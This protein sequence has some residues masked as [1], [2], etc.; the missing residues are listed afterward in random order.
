MEGSP[1]RPRLAIVVALA[2]LTLV[3][4]SCRSTLGVVAMPFLYDEVALPAE[5]VVRDV[6]YRNGDGADAEKHRLDLFLPSLST[7]ADASPSTGED[8]EGWPVVVFVHGGG[9]THG[10]R[11]LRFGGADV[12]GNIGRYLASHGI[13]AAVISYR[14]QFEFEWTDQVE[15]VARAVAWVQTHAAGYGGDPEAVFLM[16]HSAGAQLAAYVAFDGNSAGRHGLEPVCGLIP[17]SGAGYDLEDEETYERGASRR[18]Y[19]RRFRTSE[20]IPDEDWMRRAS[21]VHR[22]GPNA[23]PALVL[24]AEDDWASLHRQAAVLEGALNRA[25]VPVRLLRIAEEDHYTVVLALTDDAR[26]AGPSVLDF[27][28]RTTCG[29]DG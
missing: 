10:D 13:G 27:V 22:I 6:P 2:G 5:Q 26:A 17:V 20:E 15:D 3:L 23:P 29:R 24:Y 12:Y 18:Y 19:R 21:A 4:G 28:R 25:D 14:L 9:W 1:G 8:A 11:A 7:G 16:G